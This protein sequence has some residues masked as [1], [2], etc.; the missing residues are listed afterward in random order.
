MSLVFIG[1][2]LLQAVNRSKIALMSTVIRNSVLTVIFVA[3][4]FLIGT[5]N[6][7][8]WAMTLSEIF[9]GLLMGYW[10]YIVLMDI[11]KRD[12]KAAEPGR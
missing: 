6:S 4:A 9:G 12:A 7:L 8:W 11:A 5:L 2:S 10:A 3:A 1:S